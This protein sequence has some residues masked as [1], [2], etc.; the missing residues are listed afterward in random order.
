MALKDI[1]A[2][3][4][5]R[6]AEATLAGTLESLRDFAEVIIYDNGSTDGTLAL[7]GRYPNARV[8]TGPFLGFG[9]SRNRAAE[10]ACRD[11]V[12]AIDS[13]ERVSTEL[14]RTLDALP[15][16]D[17]R[18]AFAVLRR[19]HMLGRAVTRGGWGSDWLVRLYH[20]KAQRYDDALVHEKVKLAEGTR[21][22]R[23]AGTLEH[24]AVRDL[25]QML[26]KVNRYSEIRRKT[27]KRTSSPGL[28]V[29]RAFW[30][31]LRS[32]VLK[33][34]FLAGWRGVAIAWSN[35]NGVFYK[36][37]KAYADAAVARERNERNTIDAGSCYGAVPAPGGRTVEKA[38]NICLTHLRH[39]DHGGGTERYLNYLAH[40][41][42]E[43]GHAV[44]ILCRTHENPPH[45][46]VRFVAMHDFAL[47]KAWRLWAF[48][49]AVERHVQS[50]HYDVVFG[51]GKTWSQDAI[52]LNGGSHVTYME[53]MLH[54]PRGG[55]RPGYFRFKDR[56]AMY[57]ERRALSSPECRKIV[58]ISDMVRRDVIGRY[59]LSPERVQLIYNGVDLKRFNPGYREREGLAIRQAA[60]FGPEHVVFLFL[61]SGYER[62][63]L[64]LLIEAF[65]AVLAGCPNARLLVVGRDSSQSSYQARAKSLGIGS[66]VRFLGARSDPEACYG[67][68]DVYVL[69]TRYDP[70]AFTV[71]EALASGL[72]VVTTT[73]CG[74]GELIEGEV[75]G[76]RI[77]LG[78]DDAKRLAGVL[79][80]WC[81]PGRIRAAR[82]AARQLAEKHDINAKLVELE[83]LLLSLAR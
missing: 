6:N 20:R 61:G 32:Y 24:E 57:I 51:M 3:M 83:N 63:G 58:A 25:G 31:F 71:L 34:G 28:I 15:L 11:W 76:T 47:G 66:A 18:Q 73:T 29:L 40:H 41:L 4:I 79:L 16:D 33:G 45:P 53:I 22:T 55:F 37:M 43:H 30:A 38:M 59:D 44:T 7:A 54:E 14:A 69:P 27:I 10:L 78:E 35:A 62:K 19:N 46:R 5:T 36:Y 64:D 74:A 81:D 82:V 65:P 80:S 26:E 77:A 13:D 12:L 8:H 70:F 67:A 39:A 75:Q 56:V 68:A 49:R 48:A 21:V 42:A 23:L 50:A 1:S 52:C 72:P 9:P 60:G 17:A 2:V